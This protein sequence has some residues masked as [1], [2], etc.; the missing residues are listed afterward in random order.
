MTN[1]Q[2]LKK[3]KKKLYDINFYIKKIYN[4]NNQFELFDTV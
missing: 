2:L 3:K 4:K 1:L